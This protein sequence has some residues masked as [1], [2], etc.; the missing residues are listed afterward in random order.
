MTGIELLSA[1]VDAGFSIGMELA[2]KLVRAVTF[3]WRVRRRVRK[4]LAFSIPRRAFRKWMRDLAVEDL[5][6]PVETGGAKL[7]ATLDRQLSSVESWSADSS[8]HSKAV[9]VVEATYVAIVRYSDHADA[10]ALR[11][12]WAQARHGSILAALLQAL[13]DP[14]KLTRHDEALI[15]RR[16]SLAR[17]SVRLS[18]FDLKPANLQAAFAK[19]R[20]MA[21]T[22]IPGEIVVLIGAFG[23]GKS[24]R[25]EQ[26]FLSCI[27]RFA[28]DEMAPR[29]T[30][31]HASELG[32]Q[33]VSSA[34]TARVTQ[35]E[36]SRSGAC[37][38]IDGLD[39]V[40][41]PTAARIA[42]Q[43][44][45]FVLANQRTSCL[46]TCRPGVLNP[47]E[48]DAAAD[49]LSEEDAVL[50]I[51]EIAGRAQSTWSWNPT[52]IDA[53]RRPFFAIAAALMVADSTKPTGQA[54]LIKSLVEGALERPTSASVAVT[55]SEMFELLTKLARS[56][57]DSGNQT[58][59]LS[60]RERQLVRTST[61]IDQRPDGRI[62]FSLPILQQWFGA[63]AIAQDARIVSDALV[64]PETFDR[65]RWSM[66]IAALS[67]SPA[68]LDSLL[69]QCFRADPG[70]GAW[71]LARIA[72]GHRGFRADEL[73]I[74]AALAP[75]RLLRAARVVI[76]S[77][78]S[79]APFVFPVDR[80]DEF[81]TLGVRVSGNRVST[82]WLVEPA[83]E[84]RVLELPAHVHPFLARTDQWA[85]DRE[86]AVAEGE[87]WP[88]MLTKHRVERSILNLLNTHPRLGPPGGVWETESRYRAAR[89]M[90]N[91]QSVLFQ[92]IP[93]DQVLDMAGKLLD[94][95]GP[96]DN[97]RFQFGGRSVARWEIVDLADWITSS[98]KANIERPEPV[99]DIPIEKASS[100]WVWDLYSDEQL[101]EF[102]AEVFGLA[103][104]AY[105]EAVS[106]VFAS[107]AWSMGNGA[108][109][110]FS[111]VA[112]LSF[113]DGWAGS[114]SPGISA[115]KVSTAALT[116]VA[117]TAKDPV[118]VSANGRA[119]IS[120]SGSGPDGDKWITEY[121]EKGLSSGGAQTTNPFARG[122][123]H[124]RSVA[125]H[126]THSRPAS[127]IAASWIFDDLKA[128]KLA[129]GTFP[130]LD[131]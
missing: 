18:A 58:D 11:D 123:S 9:Q 82:G 29:P 48:Q 87:E 55:S 61:L 118:Y 119:A 79:L 100:S 95:V 121:F 85:P 101:A 74:D 80:P 92:P 17:R 30:W 46:L 25:A 83:T 91:S 73:P 104:D 97:S 99:P 53:I 10:D 24:E 8:H 102:Y 20:D 12:S 107:F 6:E 45:A 70:V 112:D 50:L 96:A 69:D 71:V 19:L 127:L 124:W 56:S 36:L 13:S 78:G 26:W 60:F 105:D 65:W 2:R 40:S 114:R 37:I 111:V 75:S 106:T 90:T 81:I 1:P 3:R 34:V 126:V 67:S 88:W 21:P 32:A 86:G 57:I 68:D 94:L 64:S 27:D 43:S 109:G 7:A 120:L 115:T 51:E 44:R 42:D 52:L 117:A 77:I 63:Q 116:D 103:C 31:L 4:G 35:A 125:N 84:D 93:A 49:G 33:S 54:D 129:D 110:P 66:A 28:D 72:D 16:E 5:A 15:L 108:D 62:E 23:S 130:Q 89:V 14:P 47:S 122:R 39:E 38:V 59:G 98:G 41:G 128:L 22:V 113:D 131:K 76:D